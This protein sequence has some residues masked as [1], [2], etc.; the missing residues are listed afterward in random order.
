[1]VTRGWDVGGQVIIII[2]FFNFLCYTAWGLE[3]T[4][5]HP[6]AAFALV[7]PGP[8][9]SGYVIPAIT[10]PPAD[11]LAGFWASPSAL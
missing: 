6:V 4:F 10:W 1:M 2:I 9:G 5:E 8:A 3:V 11:R 7:G